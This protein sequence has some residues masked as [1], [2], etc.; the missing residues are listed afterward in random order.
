MRMRFKK[1]HIHHFLSFDDATVDLSDRSYCLIKDAAKSNGSG[2]S[3]IFNALCWALTGETI[4]GLRS[5]VANIHFNDGCYVG[6]EFD[7]D[8]EAYSVTRYKNCWK[9]GNDLKISVGGEDRS[10]KGLR[11]SEEI[12]SQYLPSLTPAF[13]GSVIILGQG[14]PYKFSSNTPSGRKEVLEKL[15]KSD[16]MIDDLKKRIEERS[17]QLSGIIKDIGD[18]LIKLQTE[19]GVYSAQ[20]ESAERERDAM[21]KSRDFESE[22]ADRK[23]AIGEL[24]S[25][26]EASTQEMNGKSAERE[27]LRENVLKRSEV[28]DERLNT[29]LEQYNQ[30]NRELSDNLISLKSARNSLTQEIKRLE[31]ITDICPTDSG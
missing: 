10:G 19:S 16:Y 23:K 14:F 20:L 13:I 25:S 5:N 26:I 3:T 31:S 28:K 7:V 6:V 8:G 18:S 29:V 22:I 27:S 4:Q 21:A 12:L 9:M 24:E 17:E 11:D 30:Y 15:S 2:K 1:I